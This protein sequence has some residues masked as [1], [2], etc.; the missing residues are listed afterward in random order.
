MPNANRELEL[1]R[2][3]LAG[4]GRAAVPRHDRQAVWPWRTP[5]RPCSCWV[6]PGRAR[7]PG[8]PSRTCWQHP[9]RWRSPRP[10]RTCWR[11][12]PAGRAG[13]GRCWLL[14][15][16]GTLRAPAGVTRLR[17][18]PVVS[19]A[20]WDESLVLARA[21][22]G[23][24]RP[25]GRTGESAHWTERAEALL[26]PLLHAAHLRRAGMETV[27]RWVLRQELEPARTTLATDGVDTAADVLAGLAATDPR[28]QSGIWSTTAG[29]LAAYR[30]DAVL[31][32]AAAPNFDP[33][34]LAADR[35][36]GVRVRAGPLPGPGRADRGRLSRAGT[37][38]RLRRLGDGGRFRPGYRR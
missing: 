31:D 23:A 15:P 9:V 38:R 29:L 37:G 14:D 25:D 10:S 28:E 11:R 1:L 4:L 32:N 8:S 18:S 33:R 34:R 27:L 7:R 17:W 22:A 2:R 20:T 36:H 16:S 12:R 6:R 24:A 26:A 21:M 30:F 3:Y 35:R 5:N 13:S 19:A